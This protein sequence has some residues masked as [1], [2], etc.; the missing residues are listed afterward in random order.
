MISVVV[1][2]K[3]RKNDLQRFCDSICKQTVL[4]DELIIVDQSENATELDVNHLDSL[5]PVKHI[6]DQSISGLCAAK[7]VGIK[8]CNGDVIHFFDDDI[9]LSQ[10]YFET[11]NKHFTEHPEYYGLCGRQQNSVSSKI[12]LL[13]FDMFHRGAFK[14]I[15]K[16]C[17]SGYN[18][19][20]IVNTRILPGGVTAY[21]KEVFEKY[22]FDEVLIRYCFGEDMDFS[23]RVSFEYKLGFATDALV[24]HNH[25][26]ADR[27][28]AVES[29]A[30]KMAGYSYFYRKNIEKSILNR[31]SYL[32]VNIGIVVDACGYALRNRNLNSL[33]GLKKGQK[34][35]KEELNG[36]PF[37][38]YC[39]IA[40]KRTHND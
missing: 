26:M 29:F 9:I 35:L 10:N 12:K 15:R 20:N 38:D 17:N 24:I 14:D 25:S 8:Y 7:N 39:K 23:Y 22:R 40:E 27:Y 21:R 3:N 28:D 1:P 2:T 36:V 4:P 37:I 31:L 6:H 11:I 13:A 33:R 34:Y 32:L 5:I 30:C 19:E 16:K 18:K